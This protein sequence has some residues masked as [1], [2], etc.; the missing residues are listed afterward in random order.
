LRN[1][2]AARTA[3]LSAPATTAT[4]S[5]ARLPDRVA[6][7]TPAA[8]AVPIAPPL[9]MTATMMPGASATVTLPPAR[10]AAPLRTALRLERLS[11]GEVALVT[12]ERSPWTVRK[13]AATARSVTIQFEKREAMVVL[14]AAR[15]AGIAARTRDYLAT[16]GFTGARIGDAPATRR[17]TLIRYPAA[18]RTRAE[19]IAA[20]F[21]FSAKLEATTGPLTLLV[22][23]DAA[24]PRV[25][26]AG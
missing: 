24:S 20:Q 6:E 14:N 25:P 19:R 12:S 13:V 23:R 17:Q 5:V 4:G 22:G 21:P 7:A 15:V 1:E 10:T 9:R 8:A 26:R 11:A 2:V 18:A 3:N 16:R